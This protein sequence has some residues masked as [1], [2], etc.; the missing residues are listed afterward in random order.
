MSTLYLVRHGQASFGQMNYDRL[1]PLGEQQARLVGEYWVHW[2]IKLD[3]VYVGTLERQRVSMELARAACVAGGMAFPEPVVM[4]EWNEYNMQ[5]MLTGNVPQAIAAD[6]RVAALLRELAP[7]GRPD[8]AAN[9]RALNQLIAVAM[10][11]WVEGRLEARG[12][13]T[14]ADFMA[15]VDR[16]IER[17]RAEQGAGKTV[18]VFTSGGVISAAFQRALAAPD[19]IAM[20]A[21]WMIRNSAINEFRY[22]AARF[23]LVS[24]NTTPHLAAPELIS[25]R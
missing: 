11:L 14:W 23:S 4:P 2:G 16:G 6:P 7:N 3:A 25:L 17:V 8:F 1:S 20:Q 13:G 24:F 10:D 18:A 15:Q 5:S 19:K 21:G 9:R 22:D 12:L